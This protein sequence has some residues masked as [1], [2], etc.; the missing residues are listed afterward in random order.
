MVT[1]AS[2]LRGFMAALVTPVDRHGEVDAAGLQRVVARVLAGGASGACPVG[3][4]GEGPRLTPEQRLA[5]VEAVRDVVPPSVPVIPAPAAMTARDAVREIAAFA[6]AG[7]DAC[8]LAPP[9]YFPMADEEIVRYYRTVA[10][11]SALP[12][13]LY[14]I[15]AVT[16]V[17]IGPPV[18]AAL[19]SH[20]SIIGLKDSS[21]DLEGLQALVYAT[22]GEDFTVL[23][24][25]DTILLASLVVG[26]QGAIAASANLVP[27][28]G[29]AVYEAV[30]EERWS[31]AAA[32]QRKLFDVI[33]ACRV[34]GL[35]VGWKAALELAGVCSGAPVPPA[36]PLAADARAALA[37][38]LAALGVL[39]AARER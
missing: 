6:G 10:T 34:G 31:D 32:H 26:A 29:V 36:A 30:R 23:T 24:G 37:R 17:R 20:P 25:S 11:D 22:A 2:A 35:G 38:R 13:L 21:R 14:N 3:S 1:T 15:P 39:G 19:A 8:L 4:T 9:A 18:A 5:A 12:L 16:K 27:E 33:Q 28:L 7:A